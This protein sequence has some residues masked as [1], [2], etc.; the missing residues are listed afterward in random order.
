L[1]TSNRSKGVLPTAP[2]DQFVGFWQRMYEWIAP[3]VTG[4]LLVL[5]G[6]VVLIVAAWGGSV[7]LEGR[8]ERA[9]E[10]LG[11]SIRIAEA[12]LLPAVDKDKDKDADSEIDSEIP[13][14]KTAKERDDAVLQSV[15]ELDKTY[16]STPAALRASL[17]RA[18]VLYDQAKY[19]EAEAAYRKFLDSKPSEPALVALAHEGVGLCA[20][21]RGELDAALTA[22]QAQ[23]VGTFYRERSQWNQA[24]IYAKKKDKK[25][26]T[27]IYKDLLSKAAPQSALR[28]DVQNRLAALE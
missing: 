16:G 4:G 19:G 2:P 14:F 22:F 26:A 23:Q 1:S 21:A 20:E 11:R 27:E 6:V 25:K 28:D 13:R 17:L 12:E 9:T 5:I 10:Q 15:T 3:F 8:K 7:W 18:G 24:R